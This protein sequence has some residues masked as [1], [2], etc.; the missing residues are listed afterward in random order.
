M[1]RRYFFAASLTLAAMTLSACS[2]EKTAS[3]QAANPAPL[4]SQTDTDSGDDDDAV[5]DAGAPS[6]RIS[7]E[8]PRNVEPNGFAPIETVEQGP[9][10][11][12]P[13]VEEEPPAP[14][15]FR[16][17]G[18]ALTRGVADAVTGSGDEAP[19]E[20]PPDVAV[21]DAGAQQ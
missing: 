21:P 6:S 3:P 13:P 2:R 12:D 9:P 4:A 15:L 11:D 16:S 19:A 7:L 10:A 17:L 18:R 5:D 14:S 8:P 20:S 1:A